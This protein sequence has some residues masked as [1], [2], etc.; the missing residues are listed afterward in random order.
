MWGWNPEAL[1]SKE[2]HHVFKGGAHLFIW[3]ESGLPEP[4]IFDISGSGQISAPTTSTR[5]PTTTRPTTTNTNTPT[6]KNPNK[7]KIT[8]GS[9]KNNIFYGRVWAGAGQ[10]EQLRLH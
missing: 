4:S 9:R 6:L 7:T 8:L 3:L 1:R 2:D 10:K 5:P